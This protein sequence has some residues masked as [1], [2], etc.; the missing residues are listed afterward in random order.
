M[1]CLVCNSSMKYFFSKKYEKFPWAKMMDGIGAV[2]YFKCGYCGLVVSKTHR[3]LEHDRFV[4]LNF[5]FHSEHE[6]NNC[7]NQPP[8]LE[9]AT[10]IKIL[11][12]SGIIKSSSLL[13]FAGGYGTLS[14]ILN[15]YFQILMP[16]FE[17]Y[18]KNNSF[19][20]YVEEKELSKYEVVVSSAL[21]EHIFQRKELD[22]INRLVSDEGALILHTV[23]CENIPNNPNW[24]Y[25]EPPVHTT[26]F[27]NKSMSVLMEQWGYEASIYCPSA[28]SWVL[29]KKKSDKVDNL[30][31]KINR[32]LQN[33]Y[34]I[35]KE[36]FIDYWK[37]F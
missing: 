4:K 5:D 23:V 22:T 36:G 13:D 18:T 14:R 20:Y 7:T 27:T 29:L 9:Q 31:H 33:E 30:V 16:V 21:F 1:D 10:L 3:E 12:D 35:Y 11:A 32:E 25:L 28:K 24:F 37:G 34:L 6:K 17:P 8:Y 19:A 2:N 15:R 26:F